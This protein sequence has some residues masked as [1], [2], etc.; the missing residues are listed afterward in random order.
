MSS[1][2]QLEI[3]REHDEIV[4]GFTH[5]HTRIK[6][7]VSNTQ[8]RPLTVE[9]DLEVDQLSSKL[10]DLRY[11]L[12]VSKSRCSMAQLD[13]TITTLQDAKATHILTLHITGQVM[14]VELEELLKN[15][16]SIDYSVTDGLSGH[17]VYLKWMKLPDADTYYCISRFND[18]TVKMLTKGLFDEIQRADEFRGVEF[19]TTVFKITEIDVIG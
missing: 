7:L 11:R 15:K 18:E 16:I 14:T 9:E 1:I 4:E 17:Q 12:Q 5:V 10:A 13:R 8:T 19:Q 2:V 6:L 3:Q